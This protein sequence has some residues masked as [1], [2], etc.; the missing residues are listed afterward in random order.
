VAT[1]S[2]PSRP[3]SEQHP[4]F[5]AFAAY[6]TASPD[7]ASQYNTPSTFAE[8]TTGPEAAR[9]KSSIKRELQSLKDHSV[10]HIM[11]RSDMPSGA[12]PIKTKWVFR[13]KQT[14]TGEVD[15]FKARI[16]ACG[17]AQRYGRDFTETFSPVASTASIRLLFVLA[18]YY[19]LSLHQFD[20]ST[21]FLYGLLPEGERVYLN[22]PEGL[23]APPD[24]VCL[25]LRGLYGLRQS[26][27]IFNEHRRWANIPVPDPHMAICGSSHTFMQG[28]RI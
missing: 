5:A 9:W 11:P 2:V 17:Y 27:R 15:K 26:P 4:E 10:L 8:A 21:A 12:K 20:V 19:N 1:T 18:A 23:E 28:I 14:S 25:C 3:V 24:S 7:L 13:I 22:V 6:A 16:T